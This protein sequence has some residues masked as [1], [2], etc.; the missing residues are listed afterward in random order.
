M[1]SNRRRKPQAEKR[2][3]IVSAARELF[4]RDGYEATSMGRIAKAAGITPNT[5]YW[6]FKDKNQLLV[7]VLGDRLSE[8]L[9]D[10]AQVAGLPIPKRLL[11]MVERLRSV[12]KLV[13]SVHN[14]IGESSSVNEM[15]ANFHA[16]FEKLLD[17]ELPPGLSPESRE[18]EIRIV[19]FAIEGMF[20]HDLGDDETE[21]I[22]ERLA[23]RLEKVSSK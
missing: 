23:S 13:N 21:R 6:Y 17:A 14:L 4:E 3:E 1:P 15:H 7:Q 2:A 5:I 11:W 8:D 19:A 10:Y 20:T 16:T 18:A 9:E 22:C 12:K